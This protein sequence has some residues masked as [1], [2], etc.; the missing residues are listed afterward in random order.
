MVGWSVGAVA[1]VRRCAARTA[2]ARK[3]E[4]ERRV[5]RSWGGGEEGRSGAGMSVVGSGW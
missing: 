2:A 1:V 3:R 5:G 4:V